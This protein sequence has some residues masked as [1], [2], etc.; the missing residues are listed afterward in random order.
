MPVA[1]SIFQLMV[2]RGGKIEQEQVVKG[3]IVAEQYNGRDEQLSEGYIKHYKEWSLILIS[4]PSAHS[5]RKYG[6]QGKE[7]D[8]LRL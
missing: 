8:C 2:E 4:S 5:I 1:T 3:A 6:T 7:S